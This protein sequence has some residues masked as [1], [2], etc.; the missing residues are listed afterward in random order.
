MKATIHS[1]G[2]FRIALMLTLTVST[3]TLSLLVPF[4]STGGDAGKE[5]FSLVKAVY[6]SK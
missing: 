3:V 2:S 6:I 4:I 5:C 1:P